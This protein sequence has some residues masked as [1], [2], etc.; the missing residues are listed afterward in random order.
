MDWRLHHD[1][2][3]LM[4]YNMELKT[5]SLGIEFFHSFFYEVKKIDPWAN[6]RL[7]S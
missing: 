6:L 3:E 4:M 7:F 2:E 1:F 5:I